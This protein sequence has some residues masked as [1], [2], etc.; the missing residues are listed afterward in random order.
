MRSLPKVIHPRKLISAGAVEIPDSVNSYPEE[1]NL[2]QETGAE[3]LESPVLSQADVEQ[4]H[5]AEE[6]MFRLRIE[7]MRQK[8]EETS[9]RILRHAGE[10]REHILQEAKAQAEE[11]RRQAYEEAYQAAVTEKSQQI[12]NMLGTVEELIQ[13]LA[14]QQHQYFIRFEKAL[15]DL[16]LE[17]AAK[18]TEHAIQADPLV[19]EPMVQR[20]VAQVKNAEW[21]EV[22]ISRR[23]P[24][25]AQELKQEL[26][27]WTDARHIEAIS[28]Q[29]ELGACIVHTPQGIIDASV[30]TQLEN[31]KKR[32]HAPEH[33][34]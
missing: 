8:A 18:V 24:E 23:L 4:E 32:L 19:L 2:E 7:A 15:P 30:S 9:G 13:Q 27:E 25:L 31:L 17:I 29:N 12:S 34:G 16:A 14:L 22:R 6:E 20:A 11:I 28:D 33:N 26:R 21:L 1:E 5:R 10:E 3:A